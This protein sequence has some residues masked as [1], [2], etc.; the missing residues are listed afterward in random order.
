M[1]TQTREPFE[2]L[3]LPRKEMAVATMARYRVYDNVDH[4]TMISAGT[5]LEALQNSGLKEIYK[6]QRDRLDDSNVLDMG[7]WA[8]N[9]ALEQ[10]EREAAEAAAAAVEAAAMA[11]KAAASEAATAAATPATGDTVAPAAETTSADPSAPAS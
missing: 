1:S 6:I 8:E 2:A 3:P 11:A 5:A 7:F 10:K 9:A 4:Y